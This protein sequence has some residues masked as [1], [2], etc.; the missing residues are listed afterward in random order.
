MSTPVGKQV[1]QAH[2]NAWCPFQGKWGR[3]WCPFAFCQGVLEK[4][5]ESSL[6]DNVPIYLLDPDTWVH[7]Q[8]YHPLLWCHWVFWCDLNL[9]PSHYPLG[10]L[11]RRA[12]GPGGTLPSYP[13]S[14]PDFPSGST[15]ESLPDVIEENPD[16]D[17]N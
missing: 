17:N 9:G 15:P 3:P 4:S 12:T 10:N 11:L 14:L 8:L 13:L 1:L 5:Y 7:V 2:Q 6:P 16:A